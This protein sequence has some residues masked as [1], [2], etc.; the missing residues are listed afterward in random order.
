MTSQS[1]PVFDRNFLRQ[2]IE[3]DDRGVLLEL[4]DE[5]L[6]QLRQLKDVAADGCDS[7]QQIQALAHLCHN[8]KSSSTEI[9]AFQLAH[10]LQ[11][12]EQACLNKSDKMQALISITEHLIAAT[13]VEVEAEVA[14]LMRK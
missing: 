14:L 1:L 13:M 8:I 9:G 3:I 2:T 12:L 5:Y 11:P 4:F 7:P 10:A 6:R